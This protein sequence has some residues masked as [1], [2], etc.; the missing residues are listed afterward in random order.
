[1]SSCAASIHVVSEFV[2]QQSSP[3]DNRF[4]FA[5]TITITNTADTPFQLMSRHWIITD[6]NNHV[7]EVYGDGVV[8]EQPTIE[9]GESFT[10]TSG[11]VLCTEVGTMEGRYFTR[12]SNGDEYE[13]IIP[14]FVLSVPRAIH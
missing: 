14:R 7:E 10:Y 12:R 9:A 6:S 4:V 3:A 5:Y 1:M 13:I 11:S 2:S 8:G